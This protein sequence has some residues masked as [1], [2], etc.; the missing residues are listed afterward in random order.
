VAQF[1][2]VRAK[3]RQALANDLHFR[4]RE[5]TGA[6]TVADPDAHGLLRAAGL[7]L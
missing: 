1:L 2:C 5:L 4:R 7:T 3:V 6:N